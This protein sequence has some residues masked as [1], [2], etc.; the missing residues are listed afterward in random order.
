VCA[1]VERVLAGDHVELLERLAA[2]VGDAVLA[3]DERVVAVEVTVRKLRP[4]VPQPLRT[5][6]VRLRRA[7]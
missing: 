6:G 5:S 4:P 1:A 3:V 2:L 7:R